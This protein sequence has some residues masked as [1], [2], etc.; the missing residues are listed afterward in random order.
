MEKYSKLSLL[1]VFSA[2][3]LSSCSVTRPRAVYSSFID[4]RPYADAGFFLSPDPYAGKYESLGELKMEIVPAIL[5][6]SEKKQDSKEPRFTDGLYSNQPTL[7]STYME[8]ID[9]P[10][11]LEI[12]VGKALELG[13]N[14]IVNLDISVIYDVSKYGRTINHYEIKGLCIKILD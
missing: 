5:K 7:S 11:L 13:A 8:F 4:Y 9:S 1:L 6:T 2:M 10:E 14:G 12:V 3:I